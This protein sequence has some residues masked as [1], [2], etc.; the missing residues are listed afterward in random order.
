MRI[1][2]VSGQWHRLSPGAGLGKRLG[3]LL[4]YYYRTVA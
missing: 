2:C 3:G 1:S 4:D